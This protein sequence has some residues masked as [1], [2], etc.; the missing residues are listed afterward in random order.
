MTWKSTIRAG[1]KLRAK[2][3]HERNGRRSFPTSGTLKAKKKYSTEIFLI[4]KLALYII[5]HTAGLCVIIKLYVTSFCVMHSVLCNAIMIR[6][7][8]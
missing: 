7:Y 6:H 5:R 3:V 8:L 4:V 2:I 1:L